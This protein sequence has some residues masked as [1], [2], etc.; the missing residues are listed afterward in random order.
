MKKDEVIYLGE[1]PQYS[2][3]IGTMYG[4]KIIETDPLNMT[5]RLPSGKMS[6]P[7]SFF[8]PGGALP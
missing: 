7:L 1:E 4:V 6:P 3:Y 5:V 8:L 2:G